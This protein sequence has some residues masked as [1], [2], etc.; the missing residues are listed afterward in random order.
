MVSIRR[1]RPYDRILKD[2]SKKG[3][4]ITDTWHPALNQ[5]TRLL[6]I[7]GSMLAPDVSYF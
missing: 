7:Y 4:R 3:T 2:F 6:G 5:Q 1:P